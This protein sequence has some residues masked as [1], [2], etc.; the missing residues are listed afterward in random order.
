MM[1]K[2]LHEGD[3]ISAEVQ[4][5]F[6]DGSLSLHTRS[7]KYGKVCLNITGLTFSPA[8]SILII[9]VSGRAG[10]SVS[11]AGETSQDPFSQ[12]TMWCV[13]YIGQ[14]RIHLDLANN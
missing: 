13:N 5:V 2:Y 7:L 9:V 3:L 8:F 11:F 6:V 4:N 1:R 14:Q 12:F 10:Q